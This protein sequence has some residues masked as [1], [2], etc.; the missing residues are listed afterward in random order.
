MT[1]QIL[2]R[3]QPEH[4]AKINHD[5]AEARVQEKLVRRSINGSNTAL[6]KLCRLICKSITLRVMHKVSSREEAEDITQE[7]LVRVCEGINNLKDAKAF[8]GW[9]NTIIKNEISR[10]Y[11]KNK[12]HRVVLSVEEYLDSIVDD[13]SKDYAATE[14]D[15]TDEER[16][17]VIAIINTLP[18]RQ[19]DA[20]I[21]HYYE[22]MSVT[23]TAEV[24]GVTKQVA[25]I[26]LIRARE[27]I[28]AA[29]H[30]QEQS[31]AQKRIASPVTA[32]G[33]NS[34]IETPLMPAC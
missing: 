33:Q 21:L 27:K 20:V 28:K 16:K 14:Y 7:I 29:F 11:V 9:L 30:R 19:L 34:V 10:Y 4:C 32:S 8:G 13:K 26:H 15:R 5:A 24:M 6:K 12:K 1:N 2:R 18:E 25:S 23:Q 31:S 22:G 17:K 3:E